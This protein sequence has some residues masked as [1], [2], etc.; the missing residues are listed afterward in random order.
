MGAVTFFEISGPDTEKLRGFYQSALGLPVGESDGS[1]Y[2]SIAPGDGAIAGGL[3]DGGGAFGEPG[4]HYVIPY[5]EVDDVDAAVERAVA[6]GATVAL[7]ARVHGPT[8]S[9]HLLD[10]CGSRF[11]IFENL[12]DPGA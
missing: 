6:A 7:S 4:L 9:A 5:V 8:R 3:F 2:L 11:G 10:P 1:P 12:P